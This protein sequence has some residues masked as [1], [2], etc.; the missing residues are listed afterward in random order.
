MAGGAF[1]CAFGS[2]FGL[3]GSFAGFLA[4]IVGNF[5]NVLGISGHVVRFLGVR[6]HLLDLTLADAFKLLLEFFE[7]FVAEFLEIDQA[8]ARAFDAVNEF[9]EL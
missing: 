9:V 1:F 3:S 5:G 8:I 4:G 7:F 2:L 6:L